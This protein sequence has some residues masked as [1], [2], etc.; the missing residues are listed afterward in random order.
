MH[1]H[2]SA[3][4]SNDDQL[5]AELKAQLK[6]EFKEIFDAEASTKAITDPG[7]YDVVIDLAGR[8]CRDECGFFSIAGAQGSGKSTFAALVGFTLENCFSR[9]AAILS[10][11]D[12]YLTKAE[13]LQ[14]AKDVHP[15]LAVRG[16]PGT[17]DINRLAAAIDELRASQGVRVPVF[18]KAI[19]DRL[20]VEREI[21]PIDIIIAE[22]WCWGASPQPEELLSEPVNALEANQDPDGTWRH[23]VN[24]QLADVYQRVFSS[25]YHAF[26]KVPSMDAIVRWRWQQEQDLRAEDR[27]GQFPDEQSVRGFIGYYERITRWMLA[28]MPERA[29]VVINLDESHQISAVGYR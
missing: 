1:C 22:G 24:D 25:D 11:D 16:V 5:K 2:L 17:H 20:P 10:I 23:F 19:D 26:L 7:Y 3:V 29:D 27:T 8:L 9:A 12:F 6:K 14:L 21:D 13:R 18:D 4:N 28:S 15:M